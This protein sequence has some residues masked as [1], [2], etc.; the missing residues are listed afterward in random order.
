MPRSTVV[1]LKRVLTAILLLAA[2]SRAAEIPAPLARRI[3]IVK[4]DGLNGDLLNRYMRQIDPATGK[5]ELPWFAQIF[6]DHGTVFDN[7]YTRGISLSAP[8]WSILDTGRHAIIRG[9]VEYDRYTGEIYDYLNFFPFYLAYARKRQMDMPGVQVLDRAG[10]PLISD[11]FAYGQRF[12]SFQLF[13][14]GVH[15]A[16]LGHALRRRFSSRTILASIEGAG[17]PPL[18]QA[19]SRATEIRLERNLQNPQILY[20]DFFTGEIDH[21]GHETNDPA[22]LLAALKRLDAVVGR[23]W[24]TI[25]NS[26]LANQTVLAAVSDHGMNNVPGVISQT[27]DLVDLFN[28]PAG[29]AHHVLTDRYPMSD[30]KLRGL[31]PL[32]HRVI[33]PSTASFYLSGKASEY[34]TAWLDID[35]NERASVQFRNSDVN[36]IQILLQQLAKPDLPAAIRAAAAECLRENIDRHRAAWSREA[37][38]LGTEMAALQRA[39]ESRKQALKRL[40]KKWTE[41]QRERGESKAALRQANELAAWEHE[42]DAYT[43]YAAHLESLLALQ[44]DPVHPFKQKISEL[45]PELSL[46]DSNTV[47]DLQHYVAGPAAG[48]LVVGP[49]GKLDEE[50]SF[51]YVDYFPLLVSERARNNP[52]PELSPQPIDF[53]AMRLPDGAYAPGHG[54]SQHAYWVYGGESN[55][56]VILTDSA[57]RIAVI[58]V[59]ELSQDASGKISWAPQ[60]WRAGLPLHL[61]EDPK[62]QVPKEQDRAH[63]LS[64]WHTDREWLDATH[65][66]RY[67][68][69]VIG[70]TEELR[71]VA[72]LIPGPPGIDPELLRY[73]R[74]RRE[75]VQADLHIFA[76]D[77]WNFNVRFPNPGG[78]HGSFFRISTHAVWMLAGAGI[79]H[80]QIK[81]PYDGLNFANTVLALV[82]RTPPLPSRVVLL[83]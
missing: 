38:A 61:F 31:N 17:S 66:C 63:W 21:I 40:P 23:V 50:H 11:H 32:V 47:H 59:A 53:L 54:A 20:L 3:V 68:T 73:E 83:K 28:S 43:P 12:Q 13:Q 55:Q 27:F 35:G 69:A 82:G 41:A 78:N 14:R 39:I 58:P 30:F 65:L 29:G 81:R 49:N 76:A 36:K 15:W 79:P 19:L 18:D 25:E 67:S 5:P 26:P 8:S 1:C 52:Q 45:I 4:I 33:T 80:D 10:I 24:T 9:N 34:P 60:P 37:N 6:L 70:L 51:R 48:G 57:G 42:Y 56:L 44:P 46:G 2:L 71:P 22:A 72:P 16:T 62:L 77:H 7:F 64:A 75:L 74:M